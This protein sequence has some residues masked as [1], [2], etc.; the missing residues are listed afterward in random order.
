MIE[1]GNIVLE[2]ESSLPASREKILV[3][4]EELGF[5]PITA[6]RMATAAS[7]QMRIML[8]T[9]QPSFIRVAMD[10]ESERPALILGFTSPP[11]AGS[12]TRE[13]LGRVF[14]GV[15]VLAK[16]GGT[17]CVEVRKLLPAHR[18]EPA[19]N[20]LDRVRET[21]QRPTIE[22]LL[23][24]LTEAKERAESAD[25]LKSAFLATMSHEL[26]TPLNSILG[27]T[28][29]LL[30]GLAGPLNDEQAKQLGMVHNSA[31]HL[32]DLINDVLDLSKIEAGQLE[33]VLEPFDMREAVEKVVLAMTPIAADKGLRLTT[34][35]APEVGE[36]TS[37][38]RRVEQILLN[39]VNNAVKFTEEGEV[40][41][42][43]EVGGGWLTTRVID[44]GIGIK[45]EDM[46]RL[47]KSFQQLGSGSTRAKEGTGLGLA[48]CKRL[49]EAL[50]GELWAESRWGEGS[51]FTFKLPI[52]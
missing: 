2:D 48:I 44:T 45:A 3:M 23:R 33:V 19:E 52:A 24:R 32:L 1:L 16:D 43:C 6:T 26:R 39:L 28:S 12:T 36:I 13:V 42:E 22:E 37:D 4:A 9:G 47:F 20:V 5:D 7:E 10:K 15:D 40:R 29:I 35:I 51:T 8:R 17:E 50:G 25:R 49:A 11:I 34:E 30:Q 46:G 41:V 31:K 21:I 38:R 18:A 14:D 27:F